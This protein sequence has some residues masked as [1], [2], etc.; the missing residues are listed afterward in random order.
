MEG[1]VGPCPSDSGK[2]NRFF[3]FLHVGTFLLPFLHVRGGPFWACIPPPYENFCGH[4][5][6]GVVGIFLLWNAIMELW[7]H[8]V[9]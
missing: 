3:L 8:I 6:S 2:N 4:P 5:C 1:S 7:S 9:S